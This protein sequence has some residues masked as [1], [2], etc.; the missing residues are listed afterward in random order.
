[1]NRHPVTLAVSTFMVAVMA[2][3]PTAR[4][5]GQ[6]LGLN[7]VGG[8]YPSPAYYAALRLYR[9][10]DLES[11]LDAIDAAQRSTRTDINGKWLDSIP[12]LALLAECQWHAGDLLACQA[13]TDA[14]IRIA[15]RYRGWLGAVRWEAL[16]RPDA[17]A[18]TQR[19]FWPEANQVR[20]FPVPSSLQIAGGQILT[21]QR[22]QQ[23]G[24]IETANLKS[25]DAVEVMRGLAVIA[26]R[27]RVVLG[28]LADHEPMGSELLEATKYPAHLTVPAARVLIGAMRGVGYLGILE[29]PTVIDRM[30]RYSTVSGAAHPIT[31]WLSL[32]AL[33]VACQGDDRGKIALPASSEILALA[34]SIANASAVLGEFECIGE[35]FQLAVGSAVVS[36][37]PAVEQSAVIAARTLVRESRLASLHCYLVAADAACRAGRYESSEEHLTA[38]TVI[39]SRRDVL[40]PRLEAYGAYVRACLETAK[41]GQISSSTGGPAADAMGALALFTSGK[42]LSQRSSN[43]RRASREDRISM[44][45]N[46]QLSLVNAMIGRSL[47]NQSGKR[48]IAS[49]AEGADLNR[50]RRDP[51][52]A[53]ASHLND[54]TAMYLALLRLSAMQNQG[55]ET[56]IATDRLLAARFLHRLPLRG[57]LLQWRSLVSEPQASLSD[58]QRQTLQM[59]PPGVVEFRDRVQQDLLNPPAM[60][61]TEEAGVGIATAIRAGVSVRSPVVADEMEA[62]LS[63]LALQRAVIPTMNPPEVSESDLQTLPE[64]VGLLT[65]VFDGSKLIATSTRNG[66]TRTWTVLAAQRIPALVQM[67]LQEIGANRSRGARLSPDPQSWRL[68]M[69]KLQDVL[70]PP[71]AS[72][73]AEGLSEV[74][75]VPDGPLWYV[76]FELFETFDAVDEAPEDG[77]GPSMWVDDMK[78]GYAPTP[79]LALR[80]V[81]AATDAD[82]VALVTG[83]F[84]DPR[85]A[86]EN[87]AMVEQILLPL[88]EPLVAT[89]ANCPPTQRLGME[90][91]HLII[92]APV[93]PVVGDLLA[94]PIVPVD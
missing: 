1:M 39:A 51:V 43:S 67:L 57:R 86:E 7:D 90:I 88:V 30:K 87:S 75:I 27:R 6:G 42:A 47:G 63:H 40:W 13:T 66:R 3:M 10:G 56:L 69:R 76:P 60:V 2:V 70:L 81:G 35:A 74:V 61:Q 58:L 92:A 50:W 83:R 38:A 54:T 84:F 89:P 52:D 37:L 28:P 68:A 12:V 73:S 72:W 23:G 77:I 59:A 5:P 36:Q 14:A 45:W 16:N 15:V 29:D 17:I 49:F 11:A 55:D 32:A 20:Q 85:V 22:L 33:H 91:G 46:F 64:D 4:C 34:Q 94:T 41:G 62:R 71:G 31:P 79:G 24:V 19:R 93:T 21:E 44:P 53:V 18:A 9:D 26:H 8:Q 82:R 65:F 80:H 78:V 25:I 48:M